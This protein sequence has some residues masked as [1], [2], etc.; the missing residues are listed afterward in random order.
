MLLLKRGFH[1]QHRYSTLRICQEQFKLK[2]SPNTRCKLNNE[3]GIPVSKWCD[4]ES[5]AVT[6]IF[7]SVYE[8]SIY[9]LYKQIVISPVVPVNSMEKV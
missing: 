3:T 7:V 6:E 8:L 4:N 1:L 9:S 5:T 2:L